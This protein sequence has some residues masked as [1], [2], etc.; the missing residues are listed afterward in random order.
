MAEA[1][2]GSPLL[3]LPA[4]LA[5]MARLD[6][7]PGFREIVVRMQDTPGAFATYLAIY[8]MPSKQVQVVAE[9]FNPHVPLSFERVTPQRPLLLEG[10][11]CEG[12]GH[13]DVLDVEGVGCLLYE[14]PSP[15]DGIT[16]PFNRTF[17]FLELG[18]VGPRQTEGRWNAA[19]RTPRRSSRR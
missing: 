12:V 14:P 8:F 13:D 3:R 5:N 11:G 10:F 6:A 15:S 9:H 18:N 16:Y 4:A 19:S 2:A 17:L 1:V 7:L